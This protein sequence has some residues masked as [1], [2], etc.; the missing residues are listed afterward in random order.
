MSVSP[1]NEQIAVESMDSTARHGG[2]EG[3]TA[4]LKRRT[5][6]SSGQ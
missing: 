4:T 2:V 3:A 1:P 5:A 6:V